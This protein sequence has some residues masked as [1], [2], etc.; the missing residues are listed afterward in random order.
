MFIR[1]IQ[2]D[3]GWL[4][5][6]I[7]YPSLMHAQGVKRRKLHSLLTGRFTCRD[8]GMRLQFSR[9]SAQ[10]SIL[11]DGIC[12]HIHIQAW[13]NRDMTATHPR[14]MQLPS[15]LLIG[16]TWRQTASGGL[17]PHVNPATG[18]V[19][20]ELAMAG[21]EE[22]DEAVNVA[23]Q[24]LRD[25]K[26]S[27]PTQRRQVLSRLATALRAHRDE[28]AEIQALENGMPL[29]IASAMVDVGADWIDY[30]ASWADKLAGQVIPTDSG[31]FDYT[32]TEP[33]GVV[34]VIIPWNA[35]LGSIGM[36]AGPPLAA[37]CCVVLKPSEL[38][39][40]SSALFGQICLEAGL[41]PGV[42]TVLPGG[43][44][45][46][47]A[48][49][50]HPG[51]DKVTFTG[52]G[53]T[54]QRIAAGCAASCK[55]VLL[56]L[57]GKSA[58]LVFADANLEV[59]TAAAMGI[60]TLSG[61][62]CTV[63]SRLIVQDSVYD[64]FVPMVVDALAAVPVGDP[65]DP[66]VVMGP[67]INEI[68]C[69][70]VLGMVERAERKDGASV[71]LRGQRLGGGLADGYFMS[72][73]ALAAPDN[74]IE[75]AQEEVFGP[76]L[77]V[78]RFSGEEHAVELANDSTYGLAAYV[79]T[80]D[81]SRAVRMARQLDVGSVGINGGIAPSSP[82]APFGGVK[83]S[84]YGRE[85]GLT[86]ILEFVRIKNVMMCIEGETPAAGAAL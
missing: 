58:N 61:Q 40:F 74:T 76:V 3:K 47:A 18:K 29:A 4:D 77:T 14:S 19:Q 52:G 57:G 43:A 63:P 24:A 82:S 49:V 62:G 1:D 13:R 32:L 64:E 59:A 17:H 85:G 50:A 23:R 66:G 2:K 39:P 48:L 38:A 9:I 53:T 55:P 81:V 37:G 69:N 30:A 56:E 10:N 46:G 67:L 60:V 54:G 22:V 27:A 21:T 78:L 28:F 75:I 6:G 34:A 83:A 72:P 68:A 42:V 41:P 79:H 33:V 5:T 16:E 8:H 31:V 70:R 45:S 11:N 25:W 36:C 51:I 73:T 86:G 15:G 71:L 20:S 35:P 26:R 12:R 84:G 7:E 65:F 80:S 44:D